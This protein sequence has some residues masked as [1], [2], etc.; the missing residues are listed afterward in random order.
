[1]I[2]EKAIAVKCDGCLKLIEGVAGQ[3]APKIVVVG[4]QNVFFGHGAHWTL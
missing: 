4:R 2:Q 3:G 1:M